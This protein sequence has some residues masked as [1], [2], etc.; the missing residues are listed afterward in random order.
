[1]SPHHIRAFCA[2]CFTTIVHARVK[3]PGLTA[4]LLAIAAAEPEH[5]KECED[6]HRSGRGTQYGGDL[7]ETEHDIGHEIEKQ[8]GRQKNDGGGERIPARVVLLVGHAAMLSRIDWSVRFWLP[9]ASKLAGSSQASKAARS[10]G[11]SSSTI[12]YQAV[13]RLAPREMT[14]LRNTPSKTKPLRRGLA[15]RVFV[16]AF[17]L[18]AAVAEIVENVLRHEIVDFGGERRTGHGKAMR[19]AADL[20]HPVGGIGAHVMRH[21]D[22]LARPVVAEEFGQPAAGLHPVEPVGEFPRIGEIGCR[23]IVQAHSA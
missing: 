13:S 9:S 14:C 10:L 7:P 5:G 6:D 23:E 21:A 1:M 15:R 19:H 3:G 17:P 2:G 18:V 22:D 12:E 16:M 20:D 11:H 8:P 4:R